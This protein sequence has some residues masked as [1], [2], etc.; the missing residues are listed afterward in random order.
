[1]PRGSGVECTAMICPA[2]KCEYIRGVT[3]CADCGVALVDALDVTA[4]NPQD[5]L[6]V[7]SVWQGDDPGEYAAA[8]DALEEAG[9]AVIDQESPGYFIFPSMRPKK[10]I[11]VSSKDLEQAKKVLLDL[12]A[13]EEPEELSEGEL[14]SLQLPDSDSAESGEQDNL[15]PDLSEDWYEDDSV[16][17]VWKGGNEYFADTLSACLR[18]IGIASRKLSNSEQ[19]RVVVRPKQEARAKEVVREVVQASPPE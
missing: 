17:E 9:I 3:Q 13:W 6:E 19:W 8:K 11:Y 14:D 18:E 16:A 2:C 7:V 4:P 10:E 1:L 15:A 12:Q 5:G